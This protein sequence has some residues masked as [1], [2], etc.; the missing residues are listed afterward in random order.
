M[1]CKL[2]GAGHWT[3]AERMTSILRHVAEACPPARQGIILNSHR[4][5]GIDDDSFEK[6]I[7]RVLY[8]YFF[9]LSAFYFLYIVGV[10][11]NIHYYYYI[12]IIVWSL[13]ARS[14][15]GITGEV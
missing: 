14:I 11:D 2:K 12:I 6:N 1:L 13:L 4:V 7:Y 8:N 9:L 10:I 3:S 5:I 15:F